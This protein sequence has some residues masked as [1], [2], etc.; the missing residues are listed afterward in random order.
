M[1]GIS[2]SKEEGVYAPDAEDRELIRRLDR[3]GEKTRTTVALVCLAYN[4]PLTKAAVGRLDRLT[5][6][7]AEEI[8]GAIRG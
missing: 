5:L 6:Y 3:Y 7:S 1:D 4:L 2:G 8:L